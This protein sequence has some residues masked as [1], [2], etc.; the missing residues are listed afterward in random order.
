MLQVEHGSGTH[1]TVTEGCLQVESPQDPQKIEDE[2]EG[3]GRGR[4]SAPSSLDSSKRST[5]N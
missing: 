1:A 4:F 3:R 5:S 2:N